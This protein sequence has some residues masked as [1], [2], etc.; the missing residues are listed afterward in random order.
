V[1]R[2][3]HRIHRV[4]GLPPEGFIGFIGFEDPQPFLI[5]FGI[6]R[7]ASQRGRG[8]QAGKFESIGMH[9]RAEG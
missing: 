8:S 1:A 9:G 2:G 4:E 3:I 7:W 5:G 6:Q